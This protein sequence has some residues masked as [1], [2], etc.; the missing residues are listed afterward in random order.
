MKEKINWKSIVVSLLVII[1][2]I[3]LILLDI[4]YVNTKTYVWVSI[5]CSLIASGLVILLTALLILE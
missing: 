3:L 2:G 5:G 4:Y 1:V